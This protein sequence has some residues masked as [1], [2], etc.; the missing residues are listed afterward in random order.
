MRKFL[1]K[2]S[3]SGFLLT[4]FATAAIPNENL[5]N[6]SL[7]KSINVI[8]NIKSFNKSN[9]NIENYVNQKLKLLE[10]N[11][12]KKGLTPGQAEIA[13][14]E[15]IEK[16]EKDLEKKP[17]GNRVEKKDY[18]EYKKINNRNYQF[19]KI[20]YSIGN[21]TRIKYTDTKHDNNFV[22][23]VKVHVVPRFLNE[24]ISY[25][26]NIKKIDNIRKAHIKFIYRTGYKKKISQILSILNELQLN[27]PSCKFYADNLKQTG[28]LYILRENFVC[29]LNNK[30]SFYIKRLNNLLTNNINYDK[31][32][33]KYKQRMDKEFFILQQ[34]MNRIFNPFIKNN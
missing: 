2:L 7:N 23:L 17:L 20:G 9:T 26:E 6:F 18:P 1:L 34:L 33:N 28:Q 16:K 13:I 12:I 8:T 14:I 29:S 5:N 4:S 25:D 22:K 32:F 21:K 31:I 10:E 24:C 15:P 27:N 11:L 19:K 30:N 3:L